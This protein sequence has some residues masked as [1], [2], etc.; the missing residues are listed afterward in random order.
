MADIRTNQEKL[1]KSAEAGD[2]IMGMLQQ[3]FEDNGTPARVLDNLDGG[4]ILATLTG[5]ISGLYAALSQLAGLGAGGA[6]D[7]EAIRQASEAGAKKGAVDA[8]ASLRIV[9]DK[10][11]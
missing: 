7:I 4:Y 5:Q 11:S 3:R 9:S 1:D 6:I 10:A 8:L 2:R